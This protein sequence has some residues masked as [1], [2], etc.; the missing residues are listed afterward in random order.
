[1]MSGRLQSTLS[2]LDLVTPLFEVASDEEETP[3]ES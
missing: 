2:D 1:M 3:Q